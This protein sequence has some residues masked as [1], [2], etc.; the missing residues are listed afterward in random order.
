M[1][2]LITT[3][4]IYIPPFHGYKRDYPKYLEF[5]KWIKSVQGQ[6][7]DIDTDCLFDNQYNSNVYR[8]HDEWIDEIKDDAR[9]GLEKFKDSFFVLHPKGKDKVK[10]VK[11][12]DHRS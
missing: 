5:K 1:K 10:D 2:A 8:I 7:V 12:E 6:W 9:Q 11:F 4:Y 3:E